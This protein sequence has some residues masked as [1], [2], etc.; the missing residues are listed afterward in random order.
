MFSHITYMYIDK[1]WPD[2]T[3]LIELRYGFHLNLSVLIIANLNFAP[4][5]IRLKSQ[6]S[7]PD[8][9]VLLITEIF[10]YPNF[11]GEFKVS[12][13]NIFNLHVASI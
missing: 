8:Y 11:P 3:A 7:T 10:L 13:N 12:I 1:F 5:A 4:F 9:F 6:D 2:Q